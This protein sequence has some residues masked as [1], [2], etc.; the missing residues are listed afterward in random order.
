MATADTLALERAGRQ[1]YGSIFLLTLAHL[2]NDA[3]PNL[4]PVLIPSLMVILHFS[5]A[6]AG[7]ITAVAALT[8]QLLQPFMGLWAD[9][10]GGSW[11]VT[12]GLA[13]GAILSTA[14]LGL[15]PTYPML[16]LLI[17]LS[18]I[19]NSAFHPHASGIVG[20][21]TGRRKGLG[22]SMFLIGGNLGRG[23]A[24]L[25][26]SFAFLTWGRPGLMILSIPGLLLAFALYTYGRKIKTVG[27][28]NSGGLLATLHANRGRL[29]SLLA[30][31]G[32]RSMVAS[33]VL[34][35]L[36]IWWKLRYGHITHNAF[37]LS[38]MLLAG[39][40]GNMAGGYLS[41]VIGVI[42]VI[43]GSSVLSALLVWL[44]LHSS[45]IWLWVSI[46]LLG[47]ALFSTASVTMV[48]GQSI[49]PQHKG[50]ASGLALGLGNTLGSAGVGLLGLYAQHLS[51]VNA[52][53]LLAPISL[54]AI[55]F[56]FSFTRR[57]AATSG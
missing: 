4:Y 55:P 20:E 49:F 36:P 22:M 52:L 8:T 45:G 43:V 31:V 37:M 56:V 35:F 39:S 28:P 32:I 51:V 30:I 48:L 23:L 1:R 26:A 54:L 7:A 34:T 24:P 40:L 5:V 18:G 15:A 2:I 38:I 42:P 19:G 41:D 25:L 6:Q 53:Y 47:A 14:A 9:R 29:V 44:F 21:M 16:L 12:G 27:K 3:Y 10:V 50:M 17:L 13:L 46:G 11:F 57:A 33:A